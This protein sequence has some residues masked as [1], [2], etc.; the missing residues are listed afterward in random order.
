MMLDVLI[1]EAAISLNAVLPHRKAVIAL[2]ADLLAPISGM[3]Y[4][5]ARRAL[6]SREALGSTGVGQGAA[7]PHALSARCRRPAI[8]LITL[9]NPVHYGAPDDIDVDIMVAIV[10]PSHQDKSFLKVTAELCRLLRDPVILD[11]I[12]RADNAADIR[13]LLKRHLLLAGA[14]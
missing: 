7:L 4:N 13:T 12:R 6:S 2:A 5:E 10:W 3:T 8:A 9:E 14:A 11:A 1:D